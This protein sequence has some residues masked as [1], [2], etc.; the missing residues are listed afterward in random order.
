MRIG[1]KYLSP[2]GYGYLKNSIFKCLKYDNH[3]K[4]FR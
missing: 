3:E 4:E 2:S 1:D